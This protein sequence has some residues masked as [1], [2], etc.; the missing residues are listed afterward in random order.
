MEEKRKYNPNC[1][2]CQG[3]GIYTTSNTSGNQSTTR[4]CD[5]HIFYEIKDI[6]DD[7]VDMANDNF[8]DLI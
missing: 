3:R 6:D 8:W 1:A 2:V 5:C 4:I 7:I